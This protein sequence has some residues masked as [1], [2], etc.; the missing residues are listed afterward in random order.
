MSPLSSIAYTT[1]LV[2]VLLLGACTSS[3]SSP[4]P[5]DAAPPDSLAAPEAGGDGGLESSV[6]APITES[7]VPCSAQPT[8]VTTGVGQFTGGGGSLA[9]EHDGGVWVLP[10]TSS[11]ATEIMPD[12]TPASFSVDDEFL[13]VVE[14]A[15][16]QTLLSV[17]LATGAQWALTQ[18]YW[19]YGALCAHYAFW[20]ATTSG[21]SWTLNV[22]PADGSV[23]STALATQSSDSELVCDGTSMSWTD[24]SNRVWT[25]PV[26]GSPTGGVTLA[27][28]AAWTAQ[29]S[30]LYF[31]QM[32]MQG[33]DDFTPFTIVTEP[34]AGGAITTLATSLPPN[35]PSPAGS[36]GNGPTSIVPGPKR[37]F[38]AEWWGEG[39]VGPTGSLINWQLRAVAPAGGTPATIEAFT[40]GPDSATTGT[41]PELARD[42]VAVYWT[43]EGTLMRLCE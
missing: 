19:I 3:L 11:V 27:P 4:P 28:D 5:P 10:A 38:W 16:N 29:S 8:A 39:G 40:Y 24:D 15:T 26:G 32:G 6:H 20:W 43:S 37:V 9:Y 25:M 36:P 34:L 31:A 35:Y 1:S 2:P 7:V 17:N 13:L 22:S 41:A 14:G 12:E 21:E 42:G 18:S 30:T 23:K 33:A